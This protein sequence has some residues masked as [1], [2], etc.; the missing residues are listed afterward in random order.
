[1]AVAH[2]PVD[3]AQLRLAADSK[4]DVDGVFAVPAD[5]LLGPIERVH[6]PAALRGLLSPGRALLGDHPIA[7]KGLAKPALDP[8]VGAEIR[9]RDRAALLGL[10]AALVAPLRH[11]Q[12][13]R[14]RLPRQPL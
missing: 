1:E 9:L 14:A 3:H 7:G 10:V 6:V 4:S 12:D 11:L 2:R 8:L 13:E 5:E